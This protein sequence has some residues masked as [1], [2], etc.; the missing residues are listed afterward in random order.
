MEFKAAEDQKNKAYDVYAA[1]HTQEGIALAKDATN[2]ANAL[3]PPQPEAEEAPL[4][5]I[6]AAE[7]T[8]ERVKYCV[9]LNIEYDINRADIRPQ[10]NAEVAKV[11][12][13]M[14][15]YPTTS[16]VIEGYADEVGSE[17]YNMALS[18]RR[19]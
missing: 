15:K 4:E 11:G 1:C 7:P 9:Y 16:A 19:A 10:Y 13:F 8:P 3:C 18:Q 2:K 17:D 6:P 5:P 12:D 14:K